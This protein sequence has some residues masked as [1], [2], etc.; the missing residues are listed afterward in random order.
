MITGSSLCT[1][2]IVIATFAWLPS[3]V[4]AAD[5]SAFVVQHASSVEEKCLEV[6]TRSLPFACHRISEGTELWLPSGSSDA[7]G[8]Q[9]D[10]ASQS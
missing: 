7:G 8:M 4:A 5:Q 2:L 1:N 6:D 10:P 9:I 3:V